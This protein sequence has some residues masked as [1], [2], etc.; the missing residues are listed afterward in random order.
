MNV[1]AATIPKG[2]NGEPLDRGLYVLCVT[3]TG[4]AKVKELSPKQR[5][6]LVTK[7]LGADL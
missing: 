6:L 5:R 4:R 3:P 1:K 2:T 7:V